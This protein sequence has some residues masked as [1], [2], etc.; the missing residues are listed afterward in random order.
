M[1]VAPRRPLESVDDVGRV[2]P[3]T[4]ILQVK[5]MHVLAVPDLRCRSGC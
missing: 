1:T 3:V 5:L 2:E 4:D